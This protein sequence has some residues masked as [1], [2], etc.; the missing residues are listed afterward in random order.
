MNVSDLLADVKLAHVAKLSR[1]PLTTLWR[2]KDD[3]AIPGIVEVQAIHLKRIQKAVR[4]LK[5][6]EKLALPKKGA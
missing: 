3:N 1:I 6:A 5:A 4:R 2:W